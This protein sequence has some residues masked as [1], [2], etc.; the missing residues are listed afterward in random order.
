[1]HLNY[2]VVASYFNRLAI[3]PSQRTAYSILGRAIFA[4][5]C[6]LLMPAVL[7][8]QNNQYTKSTPDQTMRGDARIDPASHA[9]SIQIPLAAYPGRAGLS[10]PISITYSPKFRHLELDGDFQ[11]YDARPYDL[12]YLYVDTNDERS[13][14]GW[15]SSLAPPRIEGGAEGYDGYFNVNVGQPG[16]TY[17][18]IQSISRIRILLGDGS[19][20]ELRRDDT[21]RISSQSQNSGPYYAVDGS[22][23]RFEGPGDSGTLF[24]AD[25]S[26]YLSGK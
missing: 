4:G 26:R 7:L 5:F 11:P 15:T 16:G 1:M 18:Y 2:L 19:S 12:Y 21:P 20:H 22:Q 13:T 14:A 17:P 6:V 24:M 23:M 3:R 10:L 25:G 8:A 9:L